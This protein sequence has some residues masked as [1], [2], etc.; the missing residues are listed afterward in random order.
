MKIVSTTHQRLDGDTA[1]TAC[2]NLT[3]PTEYPY[4]A[5]GVPGFLD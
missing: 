4:L 1:E 5:V 2:Q 3:P